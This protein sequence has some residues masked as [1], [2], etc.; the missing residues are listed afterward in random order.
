MATQ[1]SLHNDYF[2]YVI[3][4]Q[5]GDRSVI[6]KL[7]EAN[8]AKIVSFLERQGLNTQEAED[9]FMESIV[10][11][12]EKFSNKTF[13]LTAPASSYLW[14]VCRVTALDRFRENKKIQL[15]LSENPYLSKEEEYD[16]LIATENQASQSQWNQL[17]LRSLQKLSDRCQELI[18]L[19]AQ[20][21]SGDEIAELLNIPNANAVY[22][23]KSKCRRRWLQFMQKD[24]HFLTCKPSNW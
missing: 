18:S 8:F 17:I 14:S 15:R 11:V 1:A 6:A 20:K 22:A 24:P 16:G 21:Y 7:Y 4:W 19:Y 2:T 9:C 12:M 10:V 5:E 3:P 13:S 23:A